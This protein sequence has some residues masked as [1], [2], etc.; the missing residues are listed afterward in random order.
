MGQ[1]VYTDAEMQE[2]LQKTFEEMREDQ[3]KSINRTGP[4]KRTYPK[5]G[6][7]S[8]CMCGSDKKIKHCGCQVSKMFL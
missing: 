7:N 3:K 4:M 8:K 1:N 2:K 6:R 5:M